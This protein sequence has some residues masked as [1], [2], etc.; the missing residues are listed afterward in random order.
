MSE[1]AVPLM[2]QYHKFA[3]F[4]DWV[5]A[6]PMTKYAQWYYKKNRYGWIFKP[7]VIFWTVLWGEWGQKIPQAK[8]YYRE[9]SLALKAGCKNA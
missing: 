3:V 6:R 9:E 5:M 2:E 7:I 1:F 8:K 4:M